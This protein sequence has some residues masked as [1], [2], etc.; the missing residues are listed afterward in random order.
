MS[1]SQK[2]V[3]ER[4]SGAA[5]AVAAA[6]AADALAAGFAALAEPD[7]TLE[8]GVAFAVIP[9]A[10]AAAAAAPAAPAARVDAFRP[11]SDPSLFMEPMSATGLNGA[12]RRPASG[13]SPL[14]TGMY[15]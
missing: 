3:S 5:A 2:D 4:E 14:S 7:P 10:G 12:G 8:P 6:L 15:S 1:S 13:L 9:E 11:C